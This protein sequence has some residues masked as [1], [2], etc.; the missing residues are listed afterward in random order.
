VIPEDMRQLRFQN[1]EFH[2]RVAHGGETA[3]GR[4]KLARPFSPKLGVH[5]VLRAESARGKWSMLAKKHKGLVYLEIDR[6]AHESGLRLYRYANVGNHLHVLVKARAKRDLQRFLRVLAGRIAMRV[7]GARKGKPLRARFWTRLAYT[8]LVTWGRPFE[9]AK[10]YVEKNFA[11]AHGEAAR[12]ISDWIDFP[13]RPPD[14][15]FSPV[16]H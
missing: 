10:A 9:L 7:T 2:P 8:R 11:E 12:L 14:S 5:V 15:N 6:T 1:S 4:R 16:C 13:W 3:F